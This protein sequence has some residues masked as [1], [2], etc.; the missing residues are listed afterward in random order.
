MITVEQYKQALAELAND[1]S[2]LMQNGFAMLKANYRS[3]GRLIS[4]T[5]CG[6]QNLDTGL[7]LSG[8]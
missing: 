2:K 4:A 6:Q 8:H 5:C 1:Q 3:P 7:G